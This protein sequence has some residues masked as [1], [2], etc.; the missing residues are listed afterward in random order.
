MIDSVVK[1]AIQKNLLKHYQATKRKM[2]WRD[3]HDPY[4]ILVSEIMLQQTQVSTVTAYYQRFMQRF[5]TLEALAIAPLEAVLQ[6]WEG[7]GYYNRARNLH[8][9]AQDII[10]NYGGALPT[11]ADRL[12]ELPGIGR[13]T[14]GAISSIAFGEQEPVVDGNVQRVLSRVFGVRGDVSKGKPHEAIWQ[15]AHELIPYEAPG[16]FNQALMELGATICLPNDPRC[17]Q[18][19]MGKECIANLEGLQEQLPELGVGKK[20]ISVVEVS[21]VVL[22]GVETLLTKRFPQGLWAS[23][24]EFPRVA[25]LQGETSEQAAVRAAHEIAGVKVEPVK[26]IITIK[27]NVTYHSITL[28]G[29]QCAYLSG[30]P[31]PIECAECQWVPLKSLDVYPM[32][33]PQRK[34]A[35]EIEAK[36]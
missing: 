35:K 23:L 1:K 2:P 17:A 18:C 20:S 15:L 33:V 8:K 9:A 24:W 30:E 19:P 28:W 7:L 10:A 32:A 22:R 11:K 34:I 5:P 16:D 27:H 3:S 12:R 4:A 36:G 13:Y 31:H 25:R 21:A 26:L 14:A 6:V 29:I